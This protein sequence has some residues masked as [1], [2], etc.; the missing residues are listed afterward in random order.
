MKAFFKTLCF[1]L[2]LITL[3]S[4]YKYK[5]KNPLAVPPMFEEDYKELTKQRNTENEKK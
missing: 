4:C 3:T 5:E 1:C 2:T